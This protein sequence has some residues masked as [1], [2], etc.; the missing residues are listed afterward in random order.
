MREQTDFPKLYDVHDQYRA[1]RDTSSPRYQLY[2]I[3]VE[4]W[5]IPNLHAVIPSWFQYR[6]IAEVGSATGELIAHFPPLDSGIRRFGFD[7]SRQNIQC[8]RERFPEVTFFEQDFRDVDIKVDLVILSDVLPHVPDD[9]RFLASLRSLS[10]FIVMNLPLEKCWLYRKRKYGLEDYAL[11][12]RAYD[13]QDAQRVIDGA[14]FKMLNSRVA[15]FEE[16][17]CYHKHLRLRRT[18]LPSPLI[19]KV[20][21]FGYD[22]LLRNRWLRRR[23]LPRFLFCFL[24]ASE[25]LPSKT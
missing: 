20:L 6:S 18:A 19:K 17:P 14:G 1:L 11:R 16:Q 3:E 5:K 12:L 25:T 4:Q 9:V 22:I 23:Y 13:E 8:S 21:Q 15:W 7:I 24:K 10:P 2:K